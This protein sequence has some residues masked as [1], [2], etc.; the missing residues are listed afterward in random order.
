M[1]SILP[2][3]VLL[4][5]LAPLTS[6]GQSTTLT[7]PQADAAIE[8]NAIIPVQKLERDFY[9]WHD[10]HQ[11]VIKA[12][13]QKPVDLVFIG[14]SITHMFGGIPKSP[15]ARGGE[16]WDRFFG[17]R[18]AINLGFGWDRTQN[19]LWRL[20]NG[21]LDGIRPKVAVVL[22]GTN[23]L[24]GTKNARTNNPS[25]I[26]SGI[27]AICDTIHHK[28]PQCKI[29]LLSVLPRSPQRFAKP[30]REINRRIGPLGQRD[31]VTF[32]N[33]TASFADE[34]GLPQKELMHDGV[35][36]NAS[37]YE[38]WAETMEPVLSRLLV[39]DTAVSK[40]TDKVK[41]KVVQCW[42]DSMT[43]D[44]PLVA[45]LK[46][47]QAKATFNII[48]RENRNTFVVKKKKAGEWVLF[49]FLHKEDSKEG[50]FKV[51]HLANREM[52]AIYEGFSI[53]AHCGFPLGDTP[54]ESEARLRTLRKTKAQIRDDFG[55]PVCGFVYPGGNFSPAA[56]V[57]VEK[58]GYLYARTTRS[59][60]AP[61]P[62]DNPMAQPSSCHWSHR[63]FWD[64]YE[65]AKQHGGVFYFW[66]HSCELGDDPE[67]WGWLESI[68][69]RISTDPE[70]EWVDVID[71]FTDQPA[72][73]ANLDIAG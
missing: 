27:E 29:L 36:P 41:V 5:N 28:Q 13:P 66:G 68:Y 48:P 50:G 16:T 19:V 73:T 18:N 49:S 65:A 6:W 35:H 25:E 46:K 63:Q 42:D 47:Y 61:L 45:L 4:A 33:L 22:I 52:P 3:L 12:L 71:L 40:N 7:A 43:T 32:L 20:Q 53:A 26:A 67:L 8:N 56:M 23:N 69:Q 31:Y 10:R 51:E 14:D 55:Q 54:K 39:D 2:L 59:V 60:A 58:A 9:D 30:I 11:E 70:A 1:K 37:G 24:T 15:V 64:R 57:D 38:L 72:A 34:N 62:L 44:I 17:H 21:E